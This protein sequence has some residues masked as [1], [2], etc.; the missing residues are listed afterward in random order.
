MSSLQQARSDAPASVSASRGSVLFLDVHPYAQIGHQV[1]SWIAGLLWAKDLGIG[2]AGGSLSSDPD[3]FFN[4]AT[5]QVKRQP[6]SKVI[7]LKAVGDER[8]SSSLADLRIQIERATRK[9]GGRALSFRLATNPARWDQTPAQDAVRAAVLSGPRGTDLL[10]LENGEPYIAIHIRRGDVSQD[11][12][13]AGINRWV[14]EHRYVD[15]IETIRKEPHLAHLEVRVYALGTMDDFKLLEAAGATLYLGGSRDDDFIALAAAKIL[16]L[17]PSSFSFTAALA[18]RSIVFG[19][20]PWWHFIPNEGRW[21]HMSDEWN[22]DAS[23][24]SR[25]LTAS[26]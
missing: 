23:D 19:R 21:V 9:Y 18:S 4:F 24:L 12:I 20:V 26:P 3:E 2:Y 7:R 1:S 16:I 17:S 13:S 6:R 14:P 11:Y 8:D 22:F 10:A 25:A 15:L 5:Q